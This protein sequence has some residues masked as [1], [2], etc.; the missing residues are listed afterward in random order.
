MKEVSHTLGLYPSM[1]R[2]GALWRGSGVAGCI[3][4][5]GLDSCQECGAGLLFQPNNVASLKDV[6]LGREGL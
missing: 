4:G 5:G 6:G 1:V 3:T 2:S